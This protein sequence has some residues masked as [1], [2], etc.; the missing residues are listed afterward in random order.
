MP[1]SHHTIIFVPHA[2]AKL[3]KWRVTNLQIGLAAGAFVLLTVLSSLLIWSHFNTPVNPVE[4]NRL[5]KENEELRRTNAAFESNLGKLQKQ[6]SG[7]EDKTRELAIVAGVESLGDS[8]EAGVGGPTTVEEASAGD[9]PKIQERAAKL[10]GALSA[11]EQK[12]DQRVH[13]ISSTPAIAPVKGIFTSGFG[14]RSDPLTHGRGIHQGVD[15]A[16]AP[17]QPVRA[18]A[19]GIV[20]AASEQ[21]GLGKAVFLAHGYGLSTRYGHLSAVSVRP[22][23]KVKRGD[24]I[25]RVGSTG[26][27]TGYHLHYEVRIDGEPV[28]PL[29]YIL[30][31]SPL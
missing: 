25:G 22:G 2:H 5:R 9:L 20:M 1:G 12:L 26:R 23:Q 17:G 31:N 30:D 6:L 11:V 24:V 29:A 10:V 18:S 16:A 8:V 14:T 3:R 27:S 28:N 4:I 7:Y 21:G 13:W 19:D 15:I